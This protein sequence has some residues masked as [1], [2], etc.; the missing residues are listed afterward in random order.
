MNKQNIGV[1]QLKLL[2]S[3]L[4][5]WIHLGVRG[6]GNPSIEAITV[7][8]DALCRIA[9]PTFFIITGFYY[10]NFEKKLSKTLIRIIKIVALLALVYGALYFYSAENIDL[11]VFNTDWFVNFVCF[12]SFSP[13]GVHL[14]YIFA[15]IYT[16]ISIK[17]L[18]SVLSDN[19]IYIFAFTLYL[20]GFTLNYTSYNS[21]VRSWLFLG[22]PNV[23]LGIYLSKNIKMISSRPLKVLSVVSFTLML[24]E[25]FIR[26]H[27][28]ID[29]GRDFFF[30]QSFLAAAIFILFHN[31]HVDNRFISSLLYN[32]GGYSDKIY[33]YHL[34]IFAIL[35]ELISFDGHLMILLRPFI[36]FFVTLAVCMAFSSINR[37]SKTIIRQRLTISNN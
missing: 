17:I 9:V 12:N 7:Y 24:V 15:L 34:A 2:A 16:L 36:I 27:Y 37:F 11:A 30:A 20:I 3:F 33:Y 25:V 6:V 4:V 5:V 29:A 23:C 26:S 28:S 21:Y 19:N 14:W 31:R 22:I 13:I 32:R 18:R 10:S 1:S 8:T 35:S